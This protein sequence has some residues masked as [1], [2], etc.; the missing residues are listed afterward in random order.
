MRPMDLLGR[1]LIEGYHAD[2]QTSQYGTLL[3]VKPQQTLSSLAGNM[4]RNA[5]FRFRGCYSETNGQTVLIFL[6]ENLNP[7]T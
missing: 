2:I 6:K 5:G 1:I 3:I 4:I 7:I